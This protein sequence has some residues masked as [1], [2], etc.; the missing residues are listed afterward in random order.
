MITR[1]FFDFYFDVVRPEVYELYA[2]LMPGEKQLSEA[3]TTM[4]MKHDRES[5][6]FTLRFNDITRQV[7][8]T[9]PQEVILFNVHDNICFPFF[10]DFVW[11]N[12]DE[13]IKVQIQQEFG[14]DS[15]E[16]L[17]RVLKSDRKKRNQ[18][19]LSIG[20]KLNQE[21]L[22]ALNEVI[23][24]QCFSSGGEYSFLKLVYP[25]IKEIRGKVLDAGC[26]A[27]FASLVMGQYV[28][29]NSI[30]ASRSR[31]ERAASLAQMMAEGDQQ[32]FPRV[33]QLIQTELGEL[34][35]DIE[36]PRLD[37]MIAGK[38]HGIEFHCGSLDNLPYPDQQF[39]A[40]NCLDVLEHTYNPDMILQQFYRVSR[41]GSQVFVTVP[42]SYG[43]VDQQWH[44]FND[45]NIFP[46]MLHLHHWTPDSIDEMF[47]RN[48]FK[49]CEIRPFD[50]MPWAWFEDKCHAVGETELLTKRQDEVPLQIFA[51]FEHK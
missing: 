46:S 15:S 23:S 43:L 1:E 17:A 49:A 18:F 33:M 41:P 12:I 34:L 5:I 45:G 37:N 14:A 21:Q 26:G 11:N 27:G 13:P 2:A 35:Q 48:G 47:A 20:N 4:L 51:V 40:I 25:Q 42:T 28:P 8:D 6:E 36:F 39:A 22:F 32:I 38:S 44:E 16:E 7:R 3:F 50:Y 24:L 30:D 29:V 9:Y 31:V 10:V 19:R